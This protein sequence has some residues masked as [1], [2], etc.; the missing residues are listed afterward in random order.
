MA[1]NN[2]RRNEKIIKWLELTLDNKTLDLESTY[3]AMRIANRFLQDNGLNA[4]F[5]FGHGEPTHFDINGDANPI[6]CKN[7]KVKREVNDLLNEPVSGGSSMAKKP[8]KKANNNPFSDELAKERKRAIKRS[9]CPF[10][11]P[12][13][14]SSD[15]QDGQDDKPYYGPPATSRRKLSGS[16][17]LLTNTQSVSK[18]T[19]KASKPKNMEPVNAITSLLGQYFNF[20]N[21]KKD[22]KDKEN[23]SYDICDL[24]GPKKNMFKRKRD[25]DDDDDCGGSGFGLGMSAKRSRSNWAH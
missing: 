19:S 13:S 21:N 12:S 15:E 6:N 14:D 4:R 24:N 5:R 9:R 8:A 16:K 11:A 7:V 23:E 2:G 17:N 25:N 3:S 10:P 1:D 20:G 22:R 18:S